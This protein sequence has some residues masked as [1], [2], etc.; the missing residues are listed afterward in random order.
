M[1]PGRRAIQFLFRNDSE[2]VDS[3]SLDFIL[4]I[5]NPLMPQLLEEM[6]DV[7]ADLVGSASVN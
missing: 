5:N 3:F 1:R 6:A 7:G 4:I 2:C